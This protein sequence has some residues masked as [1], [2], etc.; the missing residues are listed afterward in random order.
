MLFIEELE[1]SLKM[2]PVDGKTDILN[3]YYF[4]TNKYNHY[5]DFG[6]VKTEMFPMIQLFGDIFRIPGWYRILKIPA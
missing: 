1:T 4:L 2:D 3:K 6:M 5:V